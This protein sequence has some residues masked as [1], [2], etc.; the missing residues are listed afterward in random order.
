MVAK[1]DVKNN[2][3]NPN[4]LNP[5]Y[6]IR[7]GLF[8]SI[9]RYSS[10]LSGKM[11]DFGCGSKPYRNLFVVNEYVGLD[12]ENPGH[13][14]ENEQ[15][16]IFYDGKNIPFGDEYFDSVLCS[17]VFEHVFNLPIVLAEISRTTK[18]G[19]HVLIT[20]PFV[21]NEHEIPNDYARYTK[22]ALISLMEKHGFQCIQFSKSGN[23]ILVIF[24]LIN[25][26]FFE[27]TKGKWYRI[28]IL[29]VLYKIFGFGLF[30]CLGLFFDFI[31]PNN[32]SLYLNNIALFR[33]IS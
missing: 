22:F 4:L 9:E 32:K 23:F 30:N 8:T 24:Q 16:D 7:K 12:Y 15:I 19:G 31:L 1:R 17:E 28:T 29:R 10:S 13:P 27:L 5:F 3:F 26:Y 2:Q 11:L 33:K 14:H 21:W 25:L 18:I 20:C 6:F